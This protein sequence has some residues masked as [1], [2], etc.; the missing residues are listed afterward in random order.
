MGGNDTQAAAFKAL[1]D[2][3]SINDLLHAEDAGESMIFAACLLYPDL[4]KELV[5][6][7][8]KQNL[9]SDLR[10]SYF[11]GYQAAK[12]CD[13]LEHDLFSS[14]E[15]EP[16]AYPWLME[17]K[18][19]NE[20][21]SDAPIR[22]KLYSIF[23]ER[24]SI[25]FANDALMLWVKETIGYLLNMIETGSGSSDMTDEFIAKITSLVNNPFTLDRYM[26][27]KNA[28]FTDDVTTVNP[29]ELL[30][31]GAGGGAGPA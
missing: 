9:N 8:A 29:E 4:V 14:L 22:Q 27:L 24:S 11:T 25:L 7:V 13:L 21:E 20:T 3:S 2:M 31:H 30:G 19:T 18:E 6:K 23:M 28:D 12:W 10:K 15:E 1:T 17:T 16:L 26:G 5:C